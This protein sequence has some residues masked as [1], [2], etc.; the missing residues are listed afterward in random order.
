[1]TKQQFS[2]AWSVAQSQEDLEPV[3]DSIL[4]GCALANFQPVYCT[5]QMVAKLLR[6]QCCN[7]FGDGFDAE[8]LNQMGQIARKKFLIV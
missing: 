8:E 7:I 3:D 6:W 2:D 1:M 4:V 5:I